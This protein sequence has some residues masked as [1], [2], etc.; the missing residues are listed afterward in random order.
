MGS[1]GRKLTQIICGW[2][3]ACLAGSLSV[4]FALAHP[5]TPDEALS[6]EPLVAPASPQGIPEAPWVQIKLAP[7]P[8]HVRLNWEHWMGNE[9]YEIY[10]SPVPYFE[11]GVAPA[12]RILDL[13]GGYGGGSIVETID[14][15]IDR[16]AADDVVGPVQVIGDVQHNYFWAVQARAGGSVSGVINYVGEFDFALVRGN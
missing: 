14:D 13:S 11:P 5:I 2:C 10:R 9:G 6:G 15:G 8:S 1:L 7:N 16:Y 4:S 12:N 3:L